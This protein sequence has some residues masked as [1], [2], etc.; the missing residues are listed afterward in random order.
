MVGDGRYLARGITDDLNHGAK[1]YI[2][3]VYCYTHPSLLPICESIHDMNRVSERWCT[4][5]CVRYLSTTSLRFWYWY[6]METAVWFHCI[7]LR[8]ILLISIMVEDEKSGVW[9]RWHVDCTVLCLCLSLALCVLSIFQFV[10]SKC[11]RRWV[12]RSLIYGSWIIATWKSPFLG[13]RAD[14]GGGWPL[15]FHEQTLRFKPPTFESYHLTMIS[16]WLTW[17]NL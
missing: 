2:R 9:K 10:L 17:N 12:G 6:Q 11:A 8:F 1:T 3:Y 16:W 13:S 7:A 15:L 14:G 4:P 5:S